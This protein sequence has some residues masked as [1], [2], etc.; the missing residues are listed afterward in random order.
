VQNLRSNKL[1]RYVIVGGVAYLIEMGALF[2][3]RSTMQLDSILAVAISFWVGF[4][5]AFLLQKYVAFQHKDA[6]PKVL[7]RQL[8]FYSLLVAWN[9][10][11]TLAVAHYFANVASIFVLRTVV[12]LIVTTWNF[13]VYRW[14]FKE[15]GEG[16]TTEG[17]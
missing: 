4:V 8:A 10:I 17:A 3:L 11:F 15:Q 7:A 5:A 1:A 14:V 2:V 16:D 13:A 6:R 12:I 9:Y